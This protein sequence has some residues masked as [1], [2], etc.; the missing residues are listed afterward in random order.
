VEAHYLTAISEA[1]P[2]DTWKQI[3]DRAVKD[4]LD[5]DSSAREWLAKYLVGKTPAPNSN[6]APSA[7]STP[8]LDTPSVHFMGFIRPGN[9]RGQNGGR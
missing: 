8:G 9:R 5:G 6:A 3:V 7:A 2:P 1:C 4:A